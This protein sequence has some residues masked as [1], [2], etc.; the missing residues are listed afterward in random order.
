MPTAVGLTALCNVLKNYSIP[1]VVVHLKGPHS[2]IS[3]YANAGLIL[4]V[5]YTDSAAIASSSGSAPFPDAPNVIIYST[6]PLRARIG[7]RRSGFQ[8]TTAR[9]ER[10]LSYASVVGDD[11]SD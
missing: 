5:F 3:A 7:G 6:N 11:R 2:Q 1:S 9:G 10:R 8:E 4:A